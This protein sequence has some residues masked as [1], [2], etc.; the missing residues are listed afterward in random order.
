MN[1]F[2]LLLLLCIFISFCQ[3]ADEEPEVTS[4]P[5]IPPRVAVPFPEAMYIQNGCS[6]C[7]GER[8]DGRG[9][10]SG[11]P[12]MGYLPNFNEPST[13]R[14]GTSIDKISKSIVKGIPGTMMRA[15]PNLKSN[16]VKAI[17]EYIHKMQ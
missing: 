14:N 10:L 7:H 8:G 1:R 13:Y 6:A 11:K 15:Y 9:A 4:A 12:N 2:S 3:Q 5:P 17:A 16:E